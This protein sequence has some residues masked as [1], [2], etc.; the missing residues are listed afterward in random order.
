M[1]TFDYRNVEFFISEGG[2]TLLVSTNR[3]IEA[4]TIFKVRDLIRVC[5]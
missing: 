4:F 5:Y 1:F 3:R 2:G